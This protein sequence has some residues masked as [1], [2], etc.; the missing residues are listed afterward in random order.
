MPGLERP[1]CRRGQEELEEEPPAVDEEVLEEEDPLD[2]AVDEAP[3]E[4]FGEPDEP[5]PLAALEVSAPPDRES[6]R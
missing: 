2:P 3:S 4:V 1:L 6:V 5:D